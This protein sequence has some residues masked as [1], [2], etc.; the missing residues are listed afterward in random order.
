MYQNLIFGFYGTLVDSRTDEKSLEVWDKISIFMGYA[1]AQYTGRELKE[2]YEKY[3]EKY[4]SRIKG[5][6]YPDIDLTDVF[7]KLYKTSGVKANSKLVQYTVRAFRAI[8]TE[9]ISLYP[10]VLKMLE[11]FKAQGKKMYLLSNAQRAYITPELKLLGI[12]HY[13]DDI[14]ISSN[15]GMSKP[16]PKFFEKV[17]E[18]NELKKK[19]T[20]LIGNDYSTDI[21][22]ANKVSI[23]SLYIQTNMS[24]KKSKIE[25]SKFKILNGDHSKIVKT[26]SK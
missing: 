2:N 14:Y 24:N 18:E 20:V 25:P 10:G 9:S 3:V 12:K 4:I 8:T 26:L 17:L 1:G 19:E 7:Y 5:T 15:A 13:F 16:E 23:D 11:E 21:K 6:D 22:G